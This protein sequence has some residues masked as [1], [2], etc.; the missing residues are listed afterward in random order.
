MSVVERGNSMKMKSGGLLLALGL[1]ICGGSL[2]WASGEG[3]GHEVHLNWMDFGLRLLNFSILLAVLVKLLKKP[4]SNFFSTRR[5]DIQSTLADLEIKR[6]EAEK[7]LVAYRE[8]MATLDAETQKIVTELVAEGEIERQKIIDAAHRQ[9][10][11]IKE[12]AQIAIQ[13]EIKSARKSLQEEI[14]ELSVAAAEEVLR[15]NIR[16]ED[17]DRLIRDFMTKV[18]EAK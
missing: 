12:Q 13:Q 9:A 4:L 5:Q 15:N 7:A 14:G 10:E 17:Q 8:K 1:V 3:G 6:L 11:Y 2:A 16:P 18:V